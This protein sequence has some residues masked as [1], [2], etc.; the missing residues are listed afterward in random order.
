[1]CGDNDDDLQKSLERA[2]KLAL[3]RQDE[4]VTSGPQA[5]ARIA[6]SQISKFQYQQRH[7]KSRLS[8]QMEEFFWG[9]QLDEGMQ[10]LIP[11]FIFKEW[12]LFYFSLMEILVQNLIFTWKK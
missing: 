6:S 7:R 2:R 11:C 9:L 8:S 1:M 5:I 3:K 4:A 12:T 10:L